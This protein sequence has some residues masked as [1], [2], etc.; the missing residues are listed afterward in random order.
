MDLTP[1]Q[2]ASLH[3]RAFSDDTFLDNMQVAADDVPATETWREISRLLTGGDVLEVGPGSGHLLAAAMAEGRP[4]AGVETSAVHRE[5]IRQHWAIDQ[6]WASIV[7]VPADVRFRNVIM[8]NTIEHVYDVTE[9]LSSIRA[10]MRAGGK[11]FVS[12]CNAGGLMARA[13]GTMWSMFKPMDHVSLPSPAS[14]AAVAARAGLI[15]ERVWTTEL[16]LETPVGFA[17]ALR[18]L[19]LERV[20][21]RVTVEVVNDAPNLPSTAA[22]PSVPLSRR[23]RIAAMKYAESLDPTRL[24]VERL[25]VAA[26]VKA[27]FVAA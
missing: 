11:L 9:L 22:T 21:G 14:L 7:E 26:S 17:V 27:V 2:F 19:Y 12:T 3:E 24:V 25:G 20:H 18:D 6:V 1:E 13:V 4:V 16:P 8:L 10:H 15:P 23:A 5:Y